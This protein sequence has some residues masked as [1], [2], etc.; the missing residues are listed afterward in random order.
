MSSW[1]ERIARNILRITL[2]ILA[3]LLAGFT[4]YLI[5][6]NSDPSASPEEAATPESE[7]ISTGAVATA[8]PTATV[9]VE[10]VPLQ[11]TEEDL[12]G[13]A[14]P[15]VQAADPLEDDL[16]DV[17]LLMDGQNKT[18]FDVNL[19]YVA[20]FYGVTLRQIDVSAA[21]LTRDMFFDGDNAPL[22]LIG[23]AASTLASL[24]A[25]DLQLL[26]THVETEGVTL[27]VYEISPTTNQRLLA[28]LTDATILGASQRVDCC[29]DWLVTDDAP[30]LTR[31]FTGQAVLLDTTQTQID[32]A[33]TLAPATSEDQAVNILV[34]STEDSGDTYPI[35]ASVKRGE[36]Q[37][38]LNAGGAGQSLDQTTLREMYYG[39]PFVGSSQFATIV[40]LM[41][42]MRHTLAD[43]VWHGQADYGNLTIDDPA[44]IPVTG[45]LDYAALLAE[46][47]AHNFHTTI[48]FMPINYNRSDA[49]VVAM[50]HQHPDRYS[51]V[52]HGNNNDNYEFYYYEDFDGALFPPRPLIDQRADIQEG[53]L[54]M[55]RHRELTGLP[56]G[57]VMIFPY[58]IS[59]PET[60][61]VLKEYNFMATV[62]GQ[63]MPLGAE[64]SSDQDFDMRPANMD[65]E[66][67]P[68]IWRRSV[69]PLGTNP[70]LGR[71]IRNAAF[72]LFIDKPALFYSHAYDDELF[73]TGIDTFSPLADAINGLTGDVEWAS[74]GDII[75]H[76][77]L[78][79]QNDDGSVSVTM[80]A[81]QL[82]LANESNEP[83]TYHVS[84]EETLN[85][86]IR[87]FLI[88]G[89]D[90]LYRV[91]DGMFQSDF[92][93]PPESTVKLVIIY[94]HGDY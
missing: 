26:L 18:N 83:V 25:E 70:E 22:K 88:N 64:P 81:N 66:S 9:E 73:Q 10:N 87:R 65:Y 71:Y 38:Y 36:G 34:S 30:E 86:P 46:M 55:V 59:P 49:S 2:P 74:L 19:S 7:V 14:G 67:F 56:F 40:P 31:E 33:L 61:E 72:D 50:F 58:G 91:E 57:R 60:L 75:L 28:I 39:E 76:L 42:V 84:K 43:E 54:R 92:I 24:T 23:A 4:G 6:Q 47:E 5:T 17:L 68:V 13:E 82:E 53:L 90:A 63:D 69:S 89:Q 79:K 52:Q 48:A 11:D 27:L 62:N 94:G 29:T 93:I 32:Y 35:F 41:F 45:R 85:V 80:Y 78:Q 8:Q 51:L 37:I 3:V 44:L 20:D 15:G 77:S 12:I 1:S 21:P 16:D